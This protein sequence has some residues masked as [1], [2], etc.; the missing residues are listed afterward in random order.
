LRGYYYHTGLMFAAYNGAS[1]T[2]IALGGR[3]D[4]VGRAFGRARPATGFSLDLR[5]LAALGPAQLEPGAVLAP[6]DNSP[7]LA[8]LVADLRKSGEVVVLELPGHAGDWRKAGCSRRI[9]L[10]NGAWCVV[11]LED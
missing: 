11:A 5:E 1:P 8:A 2:A 6:V 4:E 3:Y 10:Q 9:V 7:E